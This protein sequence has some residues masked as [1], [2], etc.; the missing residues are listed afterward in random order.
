[1]EAGDSDWLCREGMGS[2][3]IFLIRKVMCLEP[4]FNNQKREDGMKEREAES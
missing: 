3:D 2:M 4:C 1:M